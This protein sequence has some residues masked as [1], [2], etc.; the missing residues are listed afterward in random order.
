MRREPAT[1]LSSLV[2]IVPTSLLAV[3]GDN[4][5]KYG[6]LV[7]LVGL[8]FY[9][10]FTMLALAVAPMIVK[11]L[12]YK[13]K[14]AYVAGN[15]IVCLAFG[16]ALS[17]SGIDGPGIAAGTTGLISAFLLVTFFEKKI[18][19]LYCSRLQKSFNLVDCRQSASSRRKN[20]KRP[21]MTRIEELLLLEEPDIHFRQIRKLSHAARGSI[22]E[23]LVAADDS[24]NDY[25]VW[26]SKDGEYCC[27]IVDPMQSRNIVAGSSVEVAMVDDFINYA[28][29]E[30]NKNTLKMY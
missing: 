5:T 18:K 28:I 6:A 11:G 25:R 1:I 4:D 20:R 23:L 17:S 2:S 14:F 15:G 8:P 26:I 19:I 10:M 27:C 21:Q 7:L 3:F 9:C 22:F 30:I 12:G 24:C 13:S 29:A 16:I